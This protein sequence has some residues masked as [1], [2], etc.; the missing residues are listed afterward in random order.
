MHARRLNDDLN[1]PISFIAMIIAVRFLVWES[2]VRAQIVG[3]ILTTTPF[4]LDG[5]RSSTGLSQLP[6]AMRLRQEKLEKTRKKQ[7]I[8]N[9][10]YWRDPAAVP[11]NSVE[12]VTFRRALGG[13]APREVKT[14]R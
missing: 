10:C 3:T 9:P 1:C 4:N 8:P 14:H 6:P 7:R 2:S 13:C 11:L 5:D 12:S